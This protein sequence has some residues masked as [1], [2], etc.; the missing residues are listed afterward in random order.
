MFI[1][2]FVKP[3]SLRCYGPS[4]LSAALVI[5]VTFR[6]ISCE[7]GNHNTE[8]NFKLDFILLLERSTTKSYKQ[9]SFKILNPIWGKKE[10]G[11][12]ISRVSM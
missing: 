10:I 8:L 7:V 4:I 2:I 12:Y 6:I 9:K 1:L 3:L 5:S 11:S